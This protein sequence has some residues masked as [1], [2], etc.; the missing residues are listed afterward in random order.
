MEIGALPK[1]E[2]SL[3]SIRAVVKCN[4]YCNFVNFTVVKVNVLT[5]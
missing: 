3:K 4:V 5:H 2:V 1:K